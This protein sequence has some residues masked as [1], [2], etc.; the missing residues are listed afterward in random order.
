MAEAQP[1]KIS[2]TSLSASDRKIDLAIS[3]ILRSGVTV[4]SVIT[5]IGAGIYLWYHSKQIPHYCTFRPQPETLTTLK[6]ILNSALQGHGEGIMQAG[7]VLLLFTPIIR[8][9][10]SILAFAKQKDWIYVVVSSIVMAVLMF[11]LLGA[12]IAIL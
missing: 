9:A 12:K 11:S 4:S 5:V 7:V 2:D 10:F 6:G 8:V 3:N 1:A